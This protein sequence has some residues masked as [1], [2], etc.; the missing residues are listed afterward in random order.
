MKLF[1]LILLLLPAQLLASVLE[2]QAILGKKIV[3]SYQGQRITLTNGVVR[4]G[5]KLIEINGGK[6]LLEVNGQRKHYRLGER[7]VMSTNFSK[8]SVP[9]LYLTADSMGMYHTSGSINGHSISFLVDTGASTIALNARH[10]RK[11]G[12]DYRNKG[13][14][15]WVST[16]SKHE[17]GY[18]VQLNKVQIG[19]ITV[20]NVDAII[21]DNNN[22]PTKALLG[23]S[24]LNNLEMK[25]D[26]SSLLLKRRW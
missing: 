17:I 7:S 3:V 15:T 6:V 10:A 20:H 2:V 22:F 8:A 13:Q 1:I 21:L 5:V 4:N 16:A 11:L 23:M 24:F 12:I 18:R 9:E 26:G 14:K 25:R 19:G